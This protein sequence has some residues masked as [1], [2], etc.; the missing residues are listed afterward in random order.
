MYMYM[1][2]L[3]YKYTHAIHTMQKD[4]VAEVMQKKWSNSRPRE[5]SGG[6]LPGVE[7]KVQ[8]HRWRREGL[9]DSPGLAAGGSHCQ[10]QVG[11]HQTTAEGRT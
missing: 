6:H 8:P 4:I 7:G 9:E 11:S 2:L 3:H 10:G 1:Y 5:K